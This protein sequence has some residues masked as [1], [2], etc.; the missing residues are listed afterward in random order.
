[1]S[2]VDQA[3]SSHSVHHQTNHISSTNE[4][5]NKPGPSTRD[6]RKSNAYSSRT[7]WDGRADDGTRNNSSTRDDEKNSSEFRIF[8][9]T[10]P[11]VTQSNNNSQETDKEQLF[12]PELHA[13]CLLALFHVNFVCAICNEAIIDCICLECGHSFCTLC[14]HQWLTSNRAC[15]TCYQF[16]K[17]DFGSQRTYCVDEFISEIYTSLQELTQEYF[18]SA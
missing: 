10:K 4:L 5:N 15:P 16:V 6:F 11:E 2:A 18:G 17:E 7:H 3:K 1:M 9:S 12:S 8:E 13:V 14:L